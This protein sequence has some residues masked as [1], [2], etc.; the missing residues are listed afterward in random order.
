[1]DELMA[2]AGINE[3]DFHPGFRMHAVASS[4]L[5]NLY[6]EMEI[7]A[8]AYA[9]LLHAAP[10]LAQE[11]AGTDLDPS[12]DP[13]NLFRFLPWLEDKFINWKPPAQNPNER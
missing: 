10:E 7:G 8:T 12:G 9:A 1:M 2:A 3:T 5:H 11:I 6:P 4:Y 13:E